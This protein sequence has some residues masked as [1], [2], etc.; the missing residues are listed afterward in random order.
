MNAPSCP[1]VD[2][3]NDTVKPASTRSR[4]RRRI[5]SLALASAVIGSTATACTSDNPPDAQTTTT[6]APT[7][8]APTTTATT[9]APTPTSLVPG[10]PEDKAA[11]G[12]TI[13]KFWEELNRSTDPP[14]P[15]RPELLALV[16]GAEKIRVGVNI[17]K[18]RTENHHS[19]RVASGASPHRSSEPEVDGDKAVLTEC[20][21]DDR[22]LYDSQG[23]VLNTDVVPYAYETHLERSEGG[24]IITQR[25][26]LPEKGG[27]PLCAGLL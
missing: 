14:N 24:W 27:H 19:R 18:L 16:A 5:A 12:R 21:I 15:E 2:R 1:N 9:I 25:W 7:T 13:D 20:A 22:I 3:K 26:G 10:S 8:A 4:I 11:V 17:Q 23:K 6:S